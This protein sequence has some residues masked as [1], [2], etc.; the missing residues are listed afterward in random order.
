MRHMQP[1]ADKGLHMVLVVNKEFPRIPHRSA[2]R[3]IGWATRQYAGA[4]GTLISL[5]LITS[6]TVTVSSACN[7]DKET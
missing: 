2:F 1:L 5:L 7:E 3:S 4:E 6:L